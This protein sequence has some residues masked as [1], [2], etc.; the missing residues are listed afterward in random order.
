[1]LRQRMYVENIGAVKIIKRRT[2]DK[3]ILDIVVLRAQ[4]HK[5]F[6]QSSLLIEVA[7]EFFP[8]VDKPFCILYRWNVVVRE[9]VLF[10]HWCLIS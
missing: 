4:L 6:I 10:C 3:D 9:I 7:W 1:M 5:E 2:L 8:I